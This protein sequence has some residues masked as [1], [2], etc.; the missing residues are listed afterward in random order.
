M[1][2]TNNMTAAIPR[3]HMAGFCQKSSPSNVLFTQENLDMVLYGYAKANNRDHI[4]GYALSGLRLGEL[5]HGLDYNTNTSSIPDLPQLTS[6]LPHSS[7]GFGLWLADTIYMV[8]DFSEI[9]GVFRRFP[10]FFRWIYVRGS[11]KAIGVVAP[12]VR[13]NTHHT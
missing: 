12:P 2:F 6:N 5:S 7:R 9:S 10:A 3:L 4:P 13:H 1:P 8:A 11:I